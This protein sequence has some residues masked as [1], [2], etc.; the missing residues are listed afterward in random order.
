MMYPANQHCTWLLSMKT[1]SRVRLSLDY[2]DL[3]D[4]L[5]CAHD[6]LLIRDGGN[7]NLPVI[8]RFCGPST[9]LPEKFLYSSSSDVTIEF[10]SDISGSRG[11]F[12]LSWDSIVKETTIAP[13]LRTTAAVIVQHRVMTGKC[14]QFKV[15]VNAHVIAQRIIPVSG[16]LKSQIVVSKG[17]RSRNLV[18]WK[19]CWER[20]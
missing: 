11:G 6:Y 1:D 20:P 12:R 2:F 15:D 18:S 16:M 4:N 5:N 10:H 9:Y 8:G 13:T 19:Q 3:E 7:P 17:P 14:I